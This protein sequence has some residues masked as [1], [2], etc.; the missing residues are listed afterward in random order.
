MLKKILLALLLIFVLIQFFRPAKNLSANEQFDISTKYEM[1]ADVKDLLHT[2]CYNCHSNL[3]KYPLYYNI[4]PIT[5]WMANHVNDAKKGLNFSE[6][7]SRKIS[8]QNKKFEDIIENVEEKEMPLPSY[9]WFGLHSEA[10]ITDQQRD[11]IINWAA[12]QQDKLKAEYPAD[13]LK[14]PPRK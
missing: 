6:F 14:M 1:N 13:S 5:W 7:V 4:Q 2:A 8:Y 12:A 9:T 11:L 3:T 10:K